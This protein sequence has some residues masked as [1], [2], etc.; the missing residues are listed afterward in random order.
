MNQTTDASAMF[1]PIWRRRWLILTVGL[2]VAIGTYFYYKQQKPTYQAATQIYLGAGAEEQ[3]SLSGSVVNGKKSSAPEPSAQ[4]VLINSPIIRS[5]AR[6]QLRRERG[7]RAGRTAL[8]GKVKAKASEKS[9]FITITAEAKSAAGAAL[10]ANVTA[11][12]YVNRQNGKYHHAIE[13]AIALSR[14]QVR[15]IEASA[16]ARTAEAAPATKGAKGSKGATTSKGKGSSAAVALQTA[17]LISKINQ[18]ETNLAIVNVRQVNPVKPK[19]VKQLSASPKRN[20]VFGFFVGL[21]L[22]SFV[23]YALARLDNRLRSLS[24]IE[25]AFG[26]EILTALSAVRRPIVIADGQPRPSKQLRE[27]LERLHTTLQFGGVAGQERPRRVLFVS[28]NGGDGQSTVIAGLA[29][30]QRDAGQATAIVE[31]DLRHP[32]LARLLGL[33]PKPGL[34]AVLDGQLSLQEALQGVGGRSPQ[35]AA[36]ELGV[37]GGPVATV[38]HTPV[39]GSASVLVGAPVAN[40]SALLASPAMDETLRALS[41]SSD[42]VLVDSPPP[43]EVSDAMPLLHLADAIVIVARVGQTRASSAHRLVQLLARTPSAPV[44]GVVANGA[45]QKDIEKYGFSSYSGRSWRSRFS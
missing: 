41:E 9:Q 44:L 30:V 14:R 33:D 39:T 7:T 1:A 45:S 22:A 5:T 31:A 35:P 2:L 19:A 10:L 34:P 43:L 20:A 8:A 21:L 13:S 12:T 37:A 27:S 29:L 3:V 17:N 18:L 23:A 6:Q 4:A 42:F 38:S 32:T 24:E 40:P 16:E 36:A 11:Q 28:A 26:T 25:E 15:R